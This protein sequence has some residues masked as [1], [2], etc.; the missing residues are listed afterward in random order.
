M[1]S[2]LSYPFIN[3][4]PIIL[5]KH[6]FSIAWLWLWPGTEAEAC[7]SQAICQPP[8][9]NTSWGWVLGET[10]QDPPGRHHVKKEW[11]RGIQYLPPA[12]GWGEMPR[13]YGK[14]MEKPHVNGIE[15]GDFLGFFFF[16][17]TSYLIQLTLDEYCVVHLPLLDI[18]SRVRCWD[19]L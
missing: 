4:F 2:L 8:T 17:V 18:V 6:W 10:I 7:V 12:S 15:I 3:D 19:V 14:S 9:T 16:L 5:F 1:I 13:I 11:S